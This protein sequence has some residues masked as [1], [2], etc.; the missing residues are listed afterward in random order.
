MDQE[1]KR[2]HPRHQAQDL[3]V[4][5]RLVKSAFVNA[6]Q[7]LSEGG[8]F[9]AAENPMPLHSDVEVVLSDGRPEP[10]ILP[11]KVVRVVWKSQGSLSE[12]QT[13]MAIEFQKDLSADVR[14]RLKTLLSRIGNSK[15]N[16]AE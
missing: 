12:T 5:Y 6:V 8:I 15:E 10:F 9:I 16:P 11:G 7:N 1:E 13:G 4:Q 14:Q 3:F 2:R